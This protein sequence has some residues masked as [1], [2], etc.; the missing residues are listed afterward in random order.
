MS[1]CFGLQQKAIVLVLRPSELKLRMEA[2]CQHCYCHTVLWGVMSASQTFIRLLVFQLHRKGMQISLLHKHKESV[3]CEYEAV[4][5]YNSLPGEQVLLADRYTE[6]L[7]IQKH[8]EQREREEEIRSRGDNLQQVFSLRSSEAYHTTCVE[9]LFSPFDRGRIPKAVIFQGHSG[10]GKSF[11]VQKIMYDWASGRL[12]KEC[13]DLVFH[14]KCKELNLLQGEKKSMMDLLNH[15]ERFSPVISQ[16]LH[17][18]PEKVLFLVDGFDELQFPLQEASLTSPNSPFTKASPEAVLSGLLKGRI[19]PESFLLV[20]TRSTASARLSK[21]LKGP[22]RFTEIMGFTE[23]GVKEYIHRFFKDEQVSEKVYECVRSNETIC[24]ACSVPVICW[25]IC[26]VFSE[27]IKD[28]EDVTKILETTTSIFVHFVSTLLQHHCRSSTQPFPTLLRNL[29]QLAERG[30]RDRQVLFD[31]KSVSE[32]V[33]DPANVPFLCKFLMKKKVSL[34]AMFSFM[35]LTFQE[36]FTALQFNLM[37]EA[38]AQKFTELLP[39]VEGFMCDIVNPHM[40]PVIQFLLG[41][42]N[43]DVSSSLKEYLSLPDSPIRA[44]LEEWVLHVIKEKKTT[45][46]VKLFILHCLYELHEEDFV[47][48]AMR[49]WDRIELVFV[50]LKR[51]DC[52]VLRYCL[53]CCGSVGSLSLRLCSITADKLR[54]LKDALY[55]CEELGLEVVGLSNTDV[56]DLVSALGEGKILSSLGIT[57]SDLSEDSMQQILTVLKKQSSLGSICL[58]MKTITARSAAMF[59]DFLQSAVIAEFRIEIA[60]MTAN[61]GE[62]LCSSLC[63]RKDTNGFMLN[64]GHQ[65]PFDNLMFIDSESC[66]PL[67]APSLSKISLMSTHSEALNMNWINFLQTFHSLRDLREDTSQFEQHVDA[68]LSCLYALSGLKKVDL[69]V[70]CLTVSWAAAVV[71]LC[72]ASPLLEDICL[73]APTDRIPLLYTLLGSTELPNQCSDEESIASYLNVGKDMFTFKLTIRP[74]SRFS[75]LRMEEDSRHQTRASLLEISLSLT[76]SPQMSNLDWRDLFQKAHMIKRSSEITTSGQYGH[77]VDALLS[78]LYYVP[79]LK[80]LELVVSCLTESWATRILSLIQNCA[81]LDELQVIAC[82]DITVD[83][84]QDGILME[85][86]IQILQKSQNHP[87]SLLKVKGWR[88]RKSTDKCTENQ[89]WSHSCNR[90]VELQFNGGCFRE[91]D[92]GPVLVIRPSPTQYFQSE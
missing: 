32:M 8:R 46:H 19:L 23:E 68:L 17:D 3:C 67:P 75:R 29:G 28:D 77:A 43:K 50:P 81:G 48:K 64:I 65:N 7:I 33:S 89:N 41:L 34:Q 54:M 63:V 31:E 73:R 85:E 86:G 53:M 26:T 4:Q 18:C 20:T 55:R 13:F 15:S 36:F 2:M 61:D 1:F 16:I 11:T 88:C 22:Q 47:R 92:Q 30:T 39:S 78:D 21:L 66:D 57:K 76:H 27:Q 25:I 58:S 90:K 37:D 45:T 84:S 62:S 38:E 49:I 69:M 6:P 51:T 83:R 35:H 87:G 44:Q 14:L 12:Y 10:Y 5:E 42:L 82:R 24:T 59:L 9:Q 74:H 72:Q 40:M 60:E 52:W 70:N 71:S 79:C 56:P 91:D 80:K